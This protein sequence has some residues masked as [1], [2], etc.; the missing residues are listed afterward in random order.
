[1]S[2]QRHAVLLTNRNLV[3]TELNGIEWLKKGERSESG[4]VGRVIKKDV[5]ES[6]G[7]GKRPDERQQGGGV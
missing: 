1:M 4:Q 6:W 7:R 5:W 3:P 2:A